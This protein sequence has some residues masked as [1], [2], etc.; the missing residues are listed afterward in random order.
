[1]TVIT[2]ETVGVPLPIQRG[3]ALAS[4]DAT[5]LGALYSIV[6]SIVLFAEEHQAIPLFA[7]MWVKDTLRKGIIAD[8][9]SDAAQ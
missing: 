5:A 1:M 7:S 8:K 2:S 9:A 4:D 6:Y 3:Q